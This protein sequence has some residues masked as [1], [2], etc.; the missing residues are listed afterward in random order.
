MKSAIESWKVYFRHKGDM[1]EALNKFDTSNPGKWE[2]DELKQYLVHLYGGL[3]VTED[4]VDYVSAHADVFRDGACIT[5]ELV[6]A[7]AAWYMLV[8][9]KKE[10]ASYCCV[11]S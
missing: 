7:T 10:N 4:E 5:Q 8:Q 3:E 9:K 2:R 1:Q 6:L 11:V